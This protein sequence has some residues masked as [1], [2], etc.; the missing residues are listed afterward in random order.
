MRLR[1]SISSFKVG[2]EAVLR[3]EVEE[4]QRLLGWNR[5][6]RIERQEDLEVGGLFRGDI[7]RR[8][9]EGLV[10]APAKALRRNYFGHEL[11]RAMQRVEVREHLVDSGLGKGRLMTETTAGDHHGVLVGEVGEV[12]RQDKKVHR[13][14]VNDLVIPDRLAGHGIES[15]DVDGQRLV[16]GDERWRKSEL[17]GVFDGLEDSGDQRHAAQRALSR[18][19]LANFRMHGTDVLF[20]RLAPS[21]ARTKGSQDGQTQGKPAPRHG[22]KGHTAVVVNPPSTAITWPVM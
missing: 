16:G 14:L 10:D 1:S 13:L 11:R 5:I 6:D 20:G 12:A 2:F 7:A 4:K 15:P 17:N 22:W 9:H 3:I 8:M 18:P 19:G 21:G